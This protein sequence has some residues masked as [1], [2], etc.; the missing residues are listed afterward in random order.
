[1]TWSVF[2]LFVAAMITF[3]IILVVLPILWQ[4]AAKRQRH[5]TNVA[6]IRQRLSELSVEAEQGL[7]TEHDLRQASDELKLALVEEHDA[8]EKHS[9]ALRYSVA[10]LIAV[11]ALAIGFYVYSNVNQLTGLKRQQEAVAAL[12]V[13]S[14]KLTSTSAANFSTEDVQMLSIAIRQRL[15]S[16]PEDAQG[17]MFLGRLNMSLGKQEEALNALE[18][19]FSISQDPQLATSYIQGL[20]A[21]GERPRIAQAQTV[22]SALIAGSPENTNYALMMAVASAQLGDLAATERAFSKVDNLLPADNPLK[23]DLQSRITQMR[24]AGKSGADESAKQATQVELTIGV[25]DKI[26]VETFPSQGYLVVFAQSID[27]ENRMP[28]AVVKLPLPSFP[29]TVTLSESDAMVAGYSLNTLSEARVVARISADEDVAI[30]PGEWQGSIQIS[31]RQ[32]QSVQ[33][34][35]TIDKEL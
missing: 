34:T 4:R 30:A 1:M 11:S 27:N 12:P 22:L 33:H 26:D 9:T 16:E 17:W 19:A 20:L 23:Q 13:L 31:L 2:H 25:D 35:L 5:A 6:L 24:G 32:G 7:I 21:T 8:E 3:L 18:K 15:R 10:A 28:A 29:V 14:E